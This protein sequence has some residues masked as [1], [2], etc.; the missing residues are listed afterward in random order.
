MGRPR[1][2]RQPALQAFYNGVK[3]SEIKDGPT[4]ASVS[5]NGRT[6]LLAVLYY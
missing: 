3:S 2:R 1:A 4:A 5:T 6:N